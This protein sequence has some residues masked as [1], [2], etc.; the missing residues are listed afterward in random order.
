MLDV[1]LSG[2]KRQPLF[3]ERAERKLVDEAAIDGG[4]RDTPTLAAGDDRLA[5]RVRPVGTEEGRR[6]D[7]VYHVVDEE[8]VRLEPDR[9]DHR[10]GADPA[11]H[12]HQRVIDRAF[13][14]V[15]HL[16]AELLG[17][18]EA[19]REMVDRDH[20][21]G[22]HKERRLDGEQPDW[23]AAPHRDGIARLDL[24]E[25]CGLPTG[26]QD[27]GQEQHLVVVNPVR[28]DDRP[29][30]AERH[31]DIFRLPARIAAGH[32][33]IAE[34]PA[35]RLPIQLLR[36]V[37]IVGREPVVARRILVLGAMVTR[38]AG[39]GE[40]HHH[41]LPLLERRLG[42]DLDHLAHELVAQDIARLHRRDEAV[43]QVEVRAA[44]CGG[45]HLDDAVP[46]IDDLGI[47]D[48]V[49][50]DVVLPVPGQRFHSPISSNCLGFIAGVATSPVSI[51]CLKR[52]RSRRAW[53]AGSRWNILATSLP[54]VPPGGS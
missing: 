42:A 46:R 32:V 44:D 35:H 36:D 4:H 38:A 50:A 26:R 37:L 24:R 30:V 20:A 11:G 54:S 7:L 6:L 29:D 22:P 31:A 12:L 17:E 48:V 1:R 8:A 3:H 25:L 13:L 18:A 16:R 9:V 10:V 51:S 2:L 15:D 19:R 23:T 49:D 41:A 47:G 53:I 45:R 33:A 40:R 5:D 43:V 39:D 27:V 52:A 34:Q 14:E 21:L 28:N